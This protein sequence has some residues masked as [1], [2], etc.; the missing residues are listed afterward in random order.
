[1]SRLLASVLIRSIIDSDRR[2]EMNFVVGFRFGKVARSA[3]DRPVISRCF[4]EAFVPAFFL[5]ELRDFDGVFS[6]RCNVSKKFGSVV[7]SGVF[8][9]TNPGYEADEFWIKATKIPNEFKVVLADLIINFG[10]LELAIDQLI[11]WA[12]GIENAQIG[13]AMTARLDIRPK[14]EMALTVLGELTDSNPYEQFKGIN[15][16]IGLACK[17][18]NAVV[19]GWWVVFGDNAV[20]MSTRT[21]CDEPGALVSGEP[22]TADDLVNDAQLTKEAERSILKLLDAPAPPPCKHTH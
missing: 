5:L 2:I 22:F 9:M 13:K 3:F 10:R 16:K 11:W 20:A 19:H 21:S 8:A 7:G 17:R 15:K 1:M 4:D 18:R 12:S 14:C 6:I